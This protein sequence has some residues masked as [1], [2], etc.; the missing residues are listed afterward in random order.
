MNTPSSVARLFQ[1]YA[2]QQFSHWRNMP[3]YYKLYSKILAKVIKAA[4]K[5]HYNR[6]IS[7]TEN[8]MKTT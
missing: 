6:I 4:K 2:L 7:N 1:G 5:L 8:K 3:H